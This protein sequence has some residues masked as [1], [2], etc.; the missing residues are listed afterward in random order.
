MESS[1]KKI[2]K[3][4]NLYLE[5]DCPGRWVIVSDKLNQLLNYEYKNVQLRKGI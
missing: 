4:E 2:I 1:L 5:C 3:D